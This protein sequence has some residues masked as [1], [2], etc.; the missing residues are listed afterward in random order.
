MFDCV[1]LSPMFLSVCTI[2]KKTCIIFWNSCTWYSMTECYLYF[3]GK[4][5]LFASTGNFEWHFL[6]NYWYIVFI[7]AY[8]FFYLS[9]RCV[10]QF[11]FIFPFAMAPQC[12]WKKL[13][14]YMHHYV[15]L[16]NLINNGFLKIQWSICHSFTKIR[17]I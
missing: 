13:L 12:N 3:Y 5:E 11:L 10:Y 2:S 16:S 1:I 7:Q 4:V 9:Q 6:V 17:T 14:W 15:A 8:Y